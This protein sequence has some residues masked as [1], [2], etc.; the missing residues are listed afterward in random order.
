ML[1]NAELRLKFPSIALTMYI[2]LTK[3]LQTPLL[4]I[5]ERDPKNCEPLLR[6]DWKEED[7]KAEIRTS[8]PGIFSKEEQIP[9]EQKELTLETIPEMYPTSSWTRVYTDGFAE[10]GVRN[11][12]SGA[13][14][15]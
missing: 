14:I 3:E 10:E 15:K 5:F 13:H 1:T 7:I 9:A 11:G 2:H 4:D 6:E 8:V 12:G